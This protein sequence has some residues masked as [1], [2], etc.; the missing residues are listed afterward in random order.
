MAEENFEEEVYD[1]PVTKFPITASL[2]PCKSK[3][4]LT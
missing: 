3:S 4:N 2:E 1:E